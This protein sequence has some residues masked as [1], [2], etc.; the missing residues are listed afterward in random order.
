[1]SAQAA[2]Q[3]RVV[4]RPRRVAAG[5]VDLRVDAHRDLSCSEFSHSLSLVT[6]GESVGGGGCYICGCRN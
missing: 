4:A 3:R 1:M 5:Q 6:A 2:V